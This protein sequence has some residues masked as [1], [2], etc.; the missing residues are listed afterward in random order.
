M[1]R[2]P[3]FLAEFKQVQLAILV[4]DLST[5]RAA[6][7][8]PTEA[9]SGEQVNRILSISGGITLVAISPERAAAFL[10]STMARPSTTDHS[11]LPSSR[12]SQ[13]VSVEAREGI[14]TGISAADRAKTLQILG[15]KVAQPRA[16]VKPGHIFPVETRSGG[17]LVKT[18]IPEGALDIVKMIGATDAALFVDLLDT[19]GELM[20]EQQ[21]QACA[22]REHLPIVTLS[23]LIRYRLQQESLVQRVAEATLPTTL[24]GEVRAIVYRSHISEI[25]HVALVKGD[26]KGDTPVVVRVQAEHTVPDVFGGN[27]PATRSH[28][29]NSLKEVGERGRGVLLYLRRPFMDPKGNSV[30]H[31]KDPPPSP[32]ATI[33]RE[34]GVGAQ[35]LRDLGVT[36]V[37]LLTSS[38]HLLEGLPSFGITVVAQH[39]I[40][41]HLP[42]SG[43]TV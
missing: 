27:A 4:D 2:F 35:I 1:S 32:S 3:H 11:I 13:Y 12:T 7:I 37:E 30:Q 14:T 39:P 16:L 22:T 8:A 21:A 36:H 40:P 26:V 24:A 6:L 29:Q 15:A 33:M 9:I 41:H 34:Y 25:E 43:H 38:T 42:T 5:S 17:V 23:E 20:S 10:L 31:L 28:L 19:Q 18:A